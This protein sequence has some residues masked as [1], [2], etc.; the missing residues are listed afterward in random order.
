MPSV[1][2]TESDSVRSTL[3]LELL[4]ETIEILARGEGC[5]ASGITKERLETLHALGHR[6]FDTGSYHDA[7]TVFTRLCLHDY[8][9]R[10]FWMGLGGSL[11]SAGNPEKAVDAYGM[12]VL[13]AALLAMSADKTGD[14]TP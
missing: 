4:G 3:R 14:A 10:R 12:A 6:L 5:E 13:C 11:Q 8:S 2:A 7:V 9:D 1:C